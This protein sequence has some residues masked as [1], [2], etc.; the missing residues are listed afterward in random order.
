MVGYGN[1]SDDRLKRE[2]ISLGF[3]PGPI[4]DSTRGIL[5]KKLEKL[6]TE[7]KKHRNKTGNSENLRRSEGVRRRHQQQSDDSEEEEKEDKEPWETQRSNLLPKL[8]RQHEPPEERFSWGR[9]TSQADSNW[10]ADRRVDDSLYP[11]RSAT[12][13]LHT[14][15]SGLWKRDR[16]NLTGEGFVTG[17][18]RYNGYSSE[19]LRLG[20][21]GE[22]SNSPYIWT[23]NK[24]QCTN[25]YR[26]DEQGT[27]N[28]WAAIDSLSHKTLPSLKRDKT[29]N[30]KPNWA[31]S[32]EY[33]LT[34]LLWVLCVVLVIVFIGILAVKSGILNTQTNSL[35]LLP[36]DCEGRKDS[37]CKAKEKQIALKILSEL[38]DFL[39]I[40]AGRFECGNPYGLSS[41]C[42]PFNTAKEHVLNVGGHAPEKFDAAV[43][44]MLNSD[45]HLGIW[46]KGEDT[47]ETVTARAKIFCFESSRPRLGVTC[48]MKN[49]L[50]TAISNLFLA[51]LGIFILW[52]VLIL[53]RYHWQR[54]EEEEKQMFDMI[55]KIIDVVK[56]HYKDWTLG[57]EQ[58]AYVGILHVRDTLIIPQDRKRLKKVWDRALQFIEDNESRLRTESQRVA[59]A[60]LRVWRWT[61]SPNEYYNERMMSAS[62]LSSSMYE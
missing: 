26:Y 34:R 6:R 44:W 16:R 37:F 54:L 47:E 52:L 38:Y 28:K 12:P 46:A 3:T 48:R 42:V 55:E 20:S 61:H 14:E 45:G 39:S 29:G 24:D 51:L 23:A 33:Y 36:S 60:D 18:A 11:R 17:S 43:D 15:A 7:A 9:D 2:L 22:S 59:G 57:I 8:H 19:N 13:A 53:L 30:W 10:R 62:P 35:K 25:R 49:A 27:H 50:Y 4:T 56:C 58:N 31:R 40:E 21:T 41:K 5:E 32:L 1:M